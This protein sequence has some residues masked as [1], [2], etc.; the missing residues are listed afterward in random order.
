MQGVQGKLSRRSKNYKIKSIKPISETRG[1][2]IQVMEM[3]PR[4]PGTNRI[5]CYITE[6][7][8]LMR[9]LYTFLKVVCIFEFLDCK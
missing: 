7:I 3:L 5:V 4:D 1:G 9:L 2:H 6:S 8:V